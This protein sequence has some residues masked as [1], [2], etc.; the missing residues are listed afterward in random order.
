MPAPSVKKG[1]ALLEEELE[2][3]QVERGGIGLDL[4]EIGVDRGVEGQVG[5]QAD[6][7]VGADR[8][9]RH[10]VV[11]RAR[12]NVALL[13]EVPGDAVGRHL[14]AARR[15]DA[16]DAR[17]VAELRREA[18]PAA[19]VRRPRRPLLRA[20]DVTPDHDAERVRWLAREAELAQRHLELGDP[21]LPVD[22][23]DDVPDAVP[24]LVFLAVVVDREVP[25]H[26]GGIHGHLHAG[27][28]VVVGVHHD[29]DP[30]RRR[31]D[32]AA[33]EQ[34]HDAVGV[35]VVHPH[36]D[37]QV[38]RIV[39][40]PGRGAELRLAVLRRVEH[41]EPVDQ[42]GLRPE[43]IVLA[44]GEHVRRR[45][46]CRHRRGRARAR[47]GGSGGGRN[48]TAPGRAR[49]REIGA[50][51]LRRGL[52]RARE[53]DDEQE[54]GDRRAAHASFQGRRKVK[55][56]PRIPSRA[57]LRERTT[58]TSTGVVSKGFAAAPGAPRRG[59]CSAATPGVSCRTA[60]ASSAWR[61]PALV[62]PNGRG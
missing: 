10:A 8:L 34:R 12:G 2:G 56:G 7:D 27:A 14:E 33:A 48:G 53:R 31:P 20:G 50:R 19:P 55:R 11:A 16:V 22:P 58:Q 60:S 24:R 13:L 51:L 57:T 15:L 41:L 38:L 6:L 61:A 4:P 49:L 30:L 52:G 40:D 5:R 39:G 18:G 17:D 1:A 37:V 32:I 26:A 43:G 3:G 46:P 47:A 21:P 54:Q 42:L 44:G 45:R 25:L 62:N 59:G 36:E 28:P 35:V 9:P 29:L 23:R